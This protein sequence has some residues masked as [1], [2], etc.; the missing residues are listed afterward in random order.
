M[1]NEVKCVARIAGKRRQG[2]ALLE[3]SELIFRGADCRLKI[4]FAEMRRVA[5]AD[6][7]L[8]VTTKDGTTVFEV[9]KVAEKW[10]EKIVH[11]KTRLEKLGVKAG[12]RVL[13]LG[14]AEPAF[15]DELRKCGADLQSGARSGAS[16]LV[17]LFVEERRGLG[18]LP[19]A[20]KRLA[21]AAGLWIAYPKGKKEIR[22]VE[23]IS[24]GRKTGLKDVKVV[25][26]SPTHTALKFVIP[27]HER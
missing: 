10:R 27:V 18:D 26:F 24:A 19:N 9:G 2:K 17:F 23:V 5:A 12:T 21:G 20:A 15:L 11:P 13:V 4:A 6:G 3:T 14:N 16:E 7:E 8:H 25:G 22:E 1:G